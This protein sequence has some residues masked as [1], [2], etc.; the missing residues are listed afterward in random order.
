[1]AGWGE[2]AAFGTA[3]GWALSS[4]AHGMVGRMVGAAGVTLL[5]TPFQMALLGLM[6]L[7]SGVD[8]SLTWRECLLLLLSGFMGITCSDFMLYKGMTVIGPQM[9]VLLIS[10]S[11]AFT[12]LL[13]W[14]F[15][16]ETLPV[17]AVAGICLTLTGIAV[18]VGDH[19]GSTLYPGQ[20]EPP[21]SRLAAGAAL[22]GGAAVLQAVS[23]IAWKA[24]MQDGASPL[25]ATFVRLATAAAILWGVGFFKGWSARAL[26]DIRTRPRVLWLL[27]GASTFSAGGMWAAGLAMVLAPAGVAATIIGLQPVLIVGVGA[28]VRRQMPSARVL[29]G[30]CVAFAGTAL[31]CLR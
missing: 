31:V 30:T 2:L 3:F 21:P 8:V 7:L 22:V 27:L 23:F 29:T 14:F 6:C 4:Y 25:W 26:H 11:S 9:S 1:M 5:R 15:L 28:V 19:G 17:Q 13:G 16:G 10:T 18:V 20:E 24:A 12:A